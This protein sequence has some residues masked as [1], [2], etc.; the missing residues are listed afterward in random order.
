MK[1]LTNAKGDVEGGKITLDPSED[2]QKLGA[3]PKRIDDEWPLKGIL[4]NMFPFQ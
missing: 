2:V 3:T 4:H 1:Y